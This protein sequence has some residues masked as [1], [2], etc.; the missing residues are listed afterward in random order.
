MAVEAAELAG[1]EW[2]LVGHGDYLSRIPGQ[3]P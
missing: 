2:M 3:S 1:Q